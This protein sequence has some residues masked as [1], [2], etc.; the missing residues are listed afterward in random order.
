MALFYRVKRAGLLGATRSCCEV[1]F[2]VKHSV[3]LYG[4][5]GCSLE[6]DSADKAC[7]TLAS[8]LD[9]ESDIYIDELYFV[10]AGGYNA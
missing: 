8:G 10:I 1:E 2:L 3:R 4:E 5:T 6:I 9:Q 7:K